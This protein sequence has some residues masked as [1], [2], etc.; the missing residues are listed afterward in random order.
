MSLVTTVITV[1]D[2]D[3][4]DGWRPIGPLTTTFTPPTGCNKIISTGDTLAFF[5]P[6]FFDRPSCFPATHSG[7]IRVYFRPGLACPSGWTSELVSGMRT[8]SRLPSLRPDETVTVCCPSGLRYT[9][10]VL[11]FAPGVGGWCLGTLTAP[12]SIEPN[13]C[14]NCEG[15]P[16]PLP[17]ANGDGVAITLIQTTI[18]FRRETAPAGVDGNSTSSLTS[19]VGP[20]AGGDDEQELPSGLSAAAKTGIAVGA[21]I[22]AILLAF[23]L[24][25]FL[26]RRRRQRRQARALQASNEAKEV[27]GTSASITELVGD[28]NPHMKT[29]ELGKGPDVLSVVPVVYVDPV[30]LD[31]GP[32]GRGSDSRPPDTYGVARSSINPGRQNT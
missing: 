18:L 25:A 20:P 6:G 22:V 16:T 17:T 7:D 23:A 19:S 12:T 15:T 4:A 31:A 32:L 14:A 21:V 8:R 28:T 13:Q 10:T 29:H 11:R 5:G 3:D 1:A 30:E 2:A 26:I 27:D 9:E 24:G